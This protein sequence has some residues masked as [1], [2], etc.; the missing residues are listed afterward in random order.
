MAENVNKPDSGEDIQNTESSPNPSLASHINSILSSQTDKSGGMKQSKKRP[1]SK[2]PDD[3]DATNGQHKKRRKKRPEDPAKEATADA[4]GAAA[5]DLSFID[6]ERL[7]SSDYDEK[8]FNT[9]LKDEEPAAYTEPA[10]HPASAIDSDKEEVYSEYIDDGPAGQDTLETISATEKIKERTD[11]EN[12]ENYTSR[13]SD[14]SASDRP[15]R[16]RS[17][18]GVRR[19]STDG[20]RRTAGAR[21]EGTRR[22]SSGTRTDGTRRTSSGTGTEGTR[23]TSSGTRPDGTRR[24]SSATR[25]DGTRRTSGTRSADGTRRPADEARRRSATG[26][27]ARKKRSSEPLS[28]EEQR[29]LDLEA[30]RA[31]RDRDIDDN[32]D[33]P[34]RMKRASRAL[35]TKVLGITLI[36]IALLIG[37]LASISINK[38]SKGSRNSGSSPAAVTSGAENAETAGSTEGAE[39]TSAETATGLANATVPAAAGL[40]VQLNAMDEMPVPTSKDEALT[41]ASAYATEYDYERA[42]AVIESFDGYT[43]DTDLTDAITNYRNIQASC[44]AVDVHSV[45]HIFFHSLLNDDRGLRADIVGEGRANSNNAAMTTADEFD[46]MME[47]MYQ[48]GYVMISLYDMVD[49]SYAADGTV[50][51]TPNTDLML[52][53]GKKAFVLSEDDLSYYH[54]YGIGTQGYATKMLIDEDGMVKCEYTNENGETLIGNYDVVPRMDAFIQAHPDFVYKGARGTVAMTGYNGVFGYRTNDYYK[55]INNPNLSSDQI[56]WLQDHPDFN[57]D[58]DV[59]AATEVANAMKAMGW[60]F[61][62]H[63]YGHWNASTHSAE[64]LQRDNERWMTVNHPILGDIDIIIFAFGGDIGTVGGYTA[65]NPKFTYFKSAGYNIFC[66]V[67]GN[68]GWTEFG[69]NYMRTGRVALDGFTMYQAMTETG[70]SHKT[71]GYDYEVLGI[72]NVAEFFNPYRITPIESE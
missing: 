26:A 33:A 47:D 15:R 29:R 38:A 45:P 36:V 54:S 51:C 40:I 42:I 49:Y 2:K 23:R 16:T 64:D 37:I 12:E 71:Y 4:A 14:V 69:S 30:K 58:A 59:A 53:Q 43:N 57:W 22:T 34:R 44:V 19:T 9:H 21:S 52:P 27:A 61:A 28:R 39:G 50:T 35:L 1:V 46:H 56:Q 20:V 55:D 8:L 6:I 10:E 17:T 72:N 41:Y 67:D 65:D 18:E 24:S 66:N 68:I 48:A 5:L 63:T 25:T 62:S 70:R 3:A 11:M 13:S 7:G 31:R 32:Y 60:T